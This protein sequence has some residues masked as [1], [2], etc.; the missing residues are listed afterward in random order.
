[1]ASRRLQFVLAAF[2]VSGLTLTNFSARS[3]SNAPQQVIEQSYAAL[4]GVMKEAKTLGYDGRF[5]RLAP[6][7]EAVFDLSFMAQ[8]TVGTYWAKATEDQRNRF[9]RAFARMTTATL[10]AR[11]DGYSGE[12][13]NI[14][15]TDDA[16]PTSALVKTQ[17]AQGDGEKVAINYLVRNSGGAWKV[18]DVYANGSISELAVKTADY[19]QVLR[20][21]GVDA[22]AT[23]LDDKVATIADQEKQTE[24]KKS[25]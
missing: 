13:F 6:I 17:I 24:G 3:E 5:Q 19:A 1:M 20:S 2:L 8:T 4:L 12:Q 10:A 16:S 14:L 18:A 25:P 21:G 15:G 7:V 23:A 9:V 22:L 11:F